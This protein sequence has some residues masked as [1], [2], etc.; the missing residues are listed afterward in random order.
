MTKP[1]SRP[2]SSR[3]AGARRKT[4]KVQKDLEAAQA[5]LHMANRV[6]AHSLPKSARDD[7]VELAL[8]QNASVEEKVEEATR[9]LEVVTELLKEEEAHSAQLEDALA[10]RDAPKTGR[11]G[12]GSSSLLPHLG[13][14]RR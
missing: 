3:A 13:G 2:L 6:L 11:S 5:E 8:V 4:A 10:G 9:E 12:E 7:M 14:N 1:G